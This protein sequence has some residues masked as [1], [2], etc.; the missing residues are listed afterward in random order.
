MVSGTL[1]L[2]LI[3]TG[4]FAYGLAADLGDYQLILDRQLLGLEEPVSPQR[5]APP[6]PVAPSWASDYIMTMISKDLSGLR[7][8]LQH[9]N[10]GQ[11]FLL[12]ENDDQHSADF[13]LISGDFDSGTATI[14]YRNQPHQFA[15][16]TGPAASP[17][18]A[19]PIQK[20]ATQVRRPGRTRVRRIRSDRPNVVPQRTFKSREELQQHLREQ[21]LDAIRTGKPP[22]P[23]PVTDEMVDELINEGW[24]LPK[25]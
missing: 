23:I 24:S 21:Q 5:P 8:G 25:K 3:F 2:S 20:V 13:K 22:L 1:K 19:S 18:P 12:M 15:I 11:A 14:S 9:K 6:Q 7:V 4:L 10:N 16:E 17:S